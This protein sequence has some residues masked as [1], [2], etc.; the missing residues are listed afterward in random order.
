MKPPM[1][2][3]QSKLDATEASAEAKSVVVRRTPPPKHTSGRGRPSK[4]RGP[5]T[6]RQA[7]V[8]CGMGATDHD[9]AKLFAVHR[10]TI[11]EWKLAHPKFSDAL[12]ETKAQ[13]DAEVVQSLYRRALGYSHDAVKVMQ[14]K[15]VPIVVPYV[16]HYPPDTTA[17][18]FW[19]K[20]RQPHLWREKVAVEASG[21]NGGPIETKDS[22]APVALPAL[23][24][25]AAKFAAIIAKAKE[26]ALSANPQS[27]RTPVH[28]PETRQGD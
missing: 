15:G 22:N 23:D 4:F 21:P 28:E 17:C 12:K 7:R 18:I 1:E 3:R 2:T 26:A 16:E 24:V 5:E 27:E 13:A 25:V 11:A 9:L 14:D 8:A 10:D 6:I 20:N 19:L